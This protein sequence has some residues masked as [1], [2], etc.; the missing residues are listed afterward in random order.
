[1]KRSRTAPLAFT[2]KSHVPPIPAASAQSGCP[3]INHFL[4]EAPNGHPMKPT[5]EQQMFD[6]PPPKG[7]KRVFVRRVLPWLALVAVFI[8]IFWSVAT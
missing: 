2:K 3:D 5:Y 6:V 1:M 7:L 4:L 8:A